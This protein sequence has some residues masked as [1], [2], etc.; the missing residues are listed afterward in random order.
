[1][2]ADEP[3]LAAL[4]VPPTAAATTITSNANNLQAALGLLCSARKIRAPEALSLGLVSRVIPD[5]KLILVPGSNDWLQ[6]VNGMTMVP[7]SLD[8]GPTLD[9]I[10]ASASMQYGSFSYAKAEHN[11]MRLDV[12]AGDAYGYLLREP[13]AIWQLDV[14]FS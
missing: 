9:S 13:N 2:A 7:N 4:G 12:Y 3:I 14:I 11:P 1:M 8:V 6:A 5:D 10:V